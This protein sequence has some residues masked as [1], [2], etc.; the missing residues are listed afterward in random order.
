[1][2]Q[3]QSDAQDGSSIYWRGIEN[4]QG[5]NALSSQQK[6][7]IGPQL[8]I[9]YGKNGSGK[10]SY[11]RIFNNAFMSR[12]DKTLLPNIYSKTKSVDRSAELIF[13]VDKEEKRVFFPKISTVKDT[14]ERFLFLMPLVQWEI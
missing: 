14:A 11:S 8:T 13:E 4:V 12:G 9:I 7:E 10:S 2:D 6:L 1:M 3:I 5:V